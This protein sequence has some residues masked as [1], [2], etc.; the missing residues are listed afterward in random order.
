MKN[1]TKTITAIILTTFVMSSFVFAENNQKKPMKTE[2]KIVKHE[3]NSSIRQKLRIQ[4]DDLMTQAKQ[5]F[6]TKK[7]GILQQAR[8]GEISKEI[9]KKTIMQA[10]KDIVETA[11][12]RIKKQTE[13]WRTENRKRVK[14][15]VHNKLR[16]IANTSPGEQ[17]K[18]Y[19]KLLGT[20]DTALRSG[21]L[22]EKN[23][24]LMNIVKETLLEGMRT[25]K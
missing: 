1:T 13:E 2:K 11:R 16:T 19:R 21:K 20:I 9:A 14:T 5:E 12:I 23:T 25:G 7:Q 4:K 24:V 18:I 10:K 6:E 15:L 17:K 22:D 8:T 3:E